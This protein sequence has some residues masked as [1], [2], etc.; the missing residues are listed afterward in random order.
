[1]RGLIYWND[2]LGTRTKRSDDF[3]KKSGRPTTSSGRS[4]TPGTSTT[5]DLSA[6]N[7]ALASVW[8]LGYHVTSKIP[9]LWYTNPTKALQLLRPS[10]RPLSPPITFLFAA[11]AAS[12]RLFRLPSQLESFFRP[13]PPPPLPTPS[14]PITT[15]LLLLLPNIFFLSSHL[16]HYLTASTSQRGTK[17]TP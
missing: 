8:S 1:M 14:V 13:L 11:L 4:L 10:F 17:A 6:S 12:D 3:V 15:L 16:F 7:T 9:T 5:V 2:N